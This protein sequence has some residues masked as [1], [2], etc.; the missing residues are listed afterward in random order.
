MYR[1][2]HGSSML[3]NSSTTERAKC[4]RLSSASFF[5]SSQGMHLQAVP[6]TKGRG[7]LL[8]PSDK[9]AREMASGQCSDLGEV[10]SIL[11]PSP[12]IQSPRRLCRGAR[13]HGGE[14]GRVEN[15]RCGAPRRGN[16][17]R[18]RRSHGADAP[19]RRN[20]KTLDSKLSCCS[21]PSSTIG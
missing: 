9:I 11:I 8:P 6:R 13:A 12:S 7:R 18:G 1:R 20:L 16:P 17:Q 21:A 3:Q 5:F 14:G 19:L 4:C 15:A 10:P 2:T